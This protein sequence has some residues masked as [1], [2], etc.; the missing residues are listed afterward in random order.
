MP[1]V[2]L[3]DADV[4]AIAEYIHSVLAEAGRQGRPPEEETPEPDILVGD[5]AAGRAYFAAH[6]TACHAATGDLQGIA[7][8]VSDPRALQNLWVSG[9]GGRGTRAAAGLPVR[10]RVTP[11]SAVPVEGRLVRIDDFIVTLIDE[12]GARRTFTRR[13]SEPAIVVDDPLAEHRR[14][15]GGY[16]DA[17]MHDVTAYLASLR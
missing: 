5:A 6:C 17:D 3:P 14:M 15:V 16:T 12:T 13:G 9:G 10:V 4:V 2:P 1:P 8:R 11:A 7:A